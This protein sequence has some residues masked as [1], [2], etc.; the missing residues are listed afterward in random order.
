MSVTLIPDDRHDLM[1][2]VDERIKNSPCYL[3][4]RLEMH[5]SF[6]V[7]IICLVTLCR[8]VASL[9]LSS[10]LCHARVSGGDS[11]QCVSIINENFTNVDLLLSFL[12][13][14]IFIEQTQMIST[15][16]AITIWKVMRARIVL[17]TWGVVMTDGTVIIWYVFRRWI[18]RDYLIR[19]LDIVA[20]VVIRLERVTS[21]TH[22]K[23]LF[24]TDISVLSQLSAQH[25]TVYDY[26]HLV[27]YF[28][29]IVQ[30]CSF[31]G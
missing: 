6:Q 19:S 3:T 27:K 7:V 25:G 10:H 22:F 26:N 17:R 9:C 1:T 15:G 13:L 20:W 31:W 21:I 16:R 11:R 5:K 28:P 8:R 30:F 29:N 24:E 4:A 18:N 23:W 12:F 14:F 2:A